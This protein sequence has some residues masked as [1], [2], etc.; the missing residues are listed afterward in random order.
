MI[1]GICEMRERVRAGLSR[2]A[3]VTWALFFSTKFVED[4]GNCVQLILLLL[5]LKFQLEKGRG[6]PMLDKTTN[7]ALLLLRITVRTFI[8]TR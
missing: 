8:A 7:H 2:Q 4:R 6:Y 5:V 3:S 1:E